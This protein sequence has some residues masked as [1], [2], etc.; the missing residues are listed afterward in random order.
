MKNCPCLDMEKAINLIHE[1]VGGFGI[2]IDSIKEAVKPAFIGWFSRSVAVATFIFCKDENGEWCVLGSERG[3]GAADFQGYWNCVCGYVEFDTTITDNC[4]KEIHEELGINVEE[5]DLKLFGIEDS[6]TAN[7]QNITFRYTIVCYDKVTSDFS[8]THKW[9]EKDEVGEIKWIP[10]ND[11]NNYK[12]AFNHNLIIQDL[13]LNKK[14]LGKA[15]FW[16]KCYVYIKRK[17]KLWQTKMKF[18]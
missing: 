7:R 17:Y 4:I 18:S 16:E 3:K 9:N 13:I 12:W 8:F 15:N 5:K 2:S 14:I 1:Q 6:P 10:L 11:I